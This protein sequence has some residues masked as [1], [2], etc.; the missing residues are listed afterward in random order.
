M[1]VGIRDWFYFEEGRKTSKYGT[2]FDFFYEHVLGHTGEGRWDEITIN[3]YLAVE[4]DEILKETEKA[5]QLVVDGWKFWIPKSLT[6]MNLDDEKVQE[7][8]KR[9]EEY[10]EKVWALMK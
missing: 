10:N 7:L 9:T 1:V 2:R 3:G 8:R 4:V 6:N 5:L